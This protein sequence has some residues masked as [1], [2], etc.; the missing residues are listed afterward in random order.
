MCPVDSLNIDHFLP[1]LGRGQPEL[2]VWCP[3]AYL[4]MLQSC[5]G[6]WTR[7]P[8]ML[9]R[10]SKACQSIGQSLGSF[11][12]KFSKIHFSGDHPSLYIALQTRAT[13]RGGWHLQ[14]KC[15]PVDHLKMD[16]LSPRHWTRRPDNADMLESSL[17]DWLQMLIFSLDIVGNDRAEKV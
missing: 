13:F 7:W 1:R 3:V 10:A 11:S 8:E 5:L 14:E 6:H 16:P 12:Q 9:S 2:L 4:P 15:R 17:V